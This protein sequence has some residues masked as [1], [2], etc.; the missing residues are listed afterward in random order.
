MPV[1]TSGSRRTR[2]STTTSARVFSRPT[3]RRRAAKLAAWEQTPD[4]ALALVIVLDQFPRNMFR[5]SARAFAADPLARAVADRA[6]GARLRP[7][8]AGAA[9]GSSSICRSSI[10]SA[11]ADQERCCALFRATGDAEL[12]EMGASCTPTSSAASAAFPTA[13]PRSAA[14]RRPRSRPSSM[15]AASPARPQTV[16]RAGRHWTLPAKAALNSLGTLPR[17][18]SHVVVGP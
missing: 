7:Q 8:D 10:P 17:R 6:H 1:P 18:R 11:C 12:A 4:G 9:S 14:P 2:R 3:R 15:A 16:E 5:G 13:T